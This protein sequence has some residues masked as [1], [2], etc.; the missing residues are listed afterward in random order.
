M[1][2]VECIFAAM[3]II[4]GTD[5]VSVTAQSV[6][7]SS[8]MGPTPR[9]KVMKFIFNRVGI[10]LRRQM[11]LMRYRTA[12]RRRN[13]GVLNISAAHTRNFGVKRRPQF[14]SLQDLTR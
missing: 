12:I 1:D 4:H 13:A 14:G 6:A 7:Q 5:G 8:S 2:A 10:L 11:I 9:E 3:T